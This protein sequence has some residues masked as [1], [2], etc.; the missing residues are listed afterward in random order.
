MVQFY[1]KE[2]ICLK[3]YINIAVIVSGIDE[4]YQ[5]CILE[6]I[7]KFALSHQI[8][9][10]HFIAF[11]GTMFDTKHDTGEYN[12]FSLPDFS[13]FDGAILLLNTISS[14]SETES[15]ISRI[16]Q[17][18]I[19][20][21]SI[22][23]DIP[24][25][26]HIGIDNSSAMEKIVEHFINYH[27]FRTFNY[28]SGPENNSESVQRYNSFRKVL[29][30]YNLP[31]DDRRVYFGDFRALS[32]RQAAEYFL[33]SGLPLPDAVISANDVM[34]VS[35]MSVFEEHNLKIP[36]DVC[37]SGFD[38]TYD[39]R[40]YSPEL[41]SIQ[42]P[43][44]ESGIL[45]CRILYEHIN[46][47]R[48]ERNF[49]L[50]MK[51][52]FTQ[53]CG[54]QSYNPETS[55]SFRKHNYKILENN[56]VSRSMINRMSC[57]LIDCDNFEEYIE[58]LKP[59]VTEIKAEEFY[60]CLCDNW[61][62]GIDGS[63]NYN[64]Q[65]NQDFSVERYTENVVIPCSFRN[66]KF[67]SIPSFESKNMVPDM[68]SDTGKNKFYYFVPLHFRERC[69]GYLAILNSDFLIKTP[70]FQTWSITICSS[71]ENIRKIECLDNAVKKLDRLYTVDT[72][73]GIYNRNGFN[74]NS[75]ELFNY[76]IKRKRPVMLMF[77][78]MD[79]L[80]V[81]NDN[82]GH[83]SGDSAIHAI[84]E[85]IRD[86]CTNGEVYC[87]FGGDEFIVFAADYTEKEA[88]ILTEKI[89]ENI[90][91]KS[92]NLNQKYTLTASIGYHIQIPDENTQI[93]QLVTIAD[94][95][96]YE[97]KKKKKKSRYLKKSGEKNE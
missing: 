89:H 59:F 33:S 52:R 66:G 46:G 97:Q 31:F 92:E 84:A 14:S 94:H 51:P 44:S 22:D 32:G 38:N 19:P 57:R 12:I 93:F 78:D 25:F 15:I 13:Y 58:K 90:R 28:I 75:T 62:A 17:A 85:A 16:K 18:G 1:R 48:T 65:M 24:E 68:F 60:L 10:A 72:L 69:L 29:K 50:D 95:V 7:Q 63:G 40:N 8:N 96:M 26:Y 80:K 79:N 70:M 55:E 88:R 2:V 54:C 73:S 11:G 27:G 83:K 77:I 20:A 30:K 35:A 53:S 86:S 23:R 42:R 76:C 9:L 34:A 3:R 41:T 74:N 4:Y 56:A 5:S 81:I 36:N 21:V 91:K 37:F 64:F 45:S 49:I 47:R 87:R 71:L 39:A 43:L 6:G 61:N 82:L 67:S